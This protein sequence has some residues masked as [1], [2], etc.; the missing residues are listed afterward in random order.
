MN[1]SGSPLAP[2][3]IAVD[4]NNALTALTQYIEL[5]NIFTYYMTIPVNYIFLIQGILQMISSVWSL[6][7][8]SL[9]VRPTKNGNTM[10]RT[11]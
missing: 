10:I 2:A 3:Y 4:S 9:S 11:A 6:T 7:V 1:K 8:I 5:E